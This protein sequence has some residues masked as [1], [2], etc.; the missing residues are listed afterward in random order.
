V[1]YEVGLDGPLSLVGA[2]YVVF[3]EAWDAH[4]HGPPSL[5]GE[6]FML[7]PSPNRFGIPAFYEL[8]A[9]AWKSNPTGSFEDWNPRVLCL[10]AEGHVP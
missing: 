4:H 9:W 7:V 6:S 1:L 2:E 3:Q 10:G 5:F 8:H